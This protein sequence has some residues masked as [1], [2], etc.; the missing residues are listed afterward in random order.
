M[1]K[2]G[3]LSQKEI[4]R[5]I[6]ELETLY[7]QKKLSKILGVS[8]DTIRRYRQGKSTPQ[9][10]EIYNKLN[11]TYNKNKNFI[12]TGAVEQKRAQIEKKS[13]SQK[14][15]AKKERHVLIYPNYMYNSPASEF[16]DT[17]NFERLEDL[18]ESGYVAAYVGGNAIPIECQFIIDGEDLKRWG[19]IINLVGIVTKEISPKADN[20]WTGQDASLEVF[21]TYYRLIPGLKKDNTFEQKMDKTREFFFNNINIDKGY[22]IA[23]LGFY[24]N[25]GDEL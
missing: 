20:S 22:T 18:Q 5:R 12:D 3:R 10:K 7:G 25:E 11:K 4:Q 21:P 24:F 1:R 9:T 2:V 14:V 8:G 19:K 15:G 17:R 23:Y 13:K 16:N 6:L